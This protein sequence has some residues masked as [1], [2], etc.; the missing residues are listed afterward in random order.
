[1]PSAIPSTGRFQLSA[2]V[3]RCG[4]I[5]LTVVSFI[6]AAGAAHGQTVF[7]QNGFGTNHGTYSVL[8]YE[9]IDP[10]SGNLMLVVT[11]LAL[12]GNAGLDLRVQRVYN[13]AVYPDFESGSL[14]LEEDS[15]AG[16]GWRLHF[17]RVLHEDS[18]DS[19]GTQIEMGDGSRHS[20]YTTS[21]RPEGWTTKNFWIYD[22]SAH[23]LKLPNGTVYTF[24]HAVFLNARLGVVRYVT[25]IRDPFNNTITFSYFSSPGPPDGVQQIQQTLAPGQTRTVTFTYDGTYKGLRTMTFDGRTWTYEHQAFGPPG[26]SALV[27]TQAPTGKPWVYTYEST[28]GH[29]ALASMLVPGGGQVSYVYGDVT[30]YAGAT[31][32]PA[33]VV[34]SRSISGHQITAGTWTFTYSDGPNKDQS[35]VQSPCGTVRYRF[36]GIGLSGDFS[37]WSTGALAEQTVEEAGT[38]LER[39]ELTWVRSDAISPDAVPGEGGL[40][41]DAD[42]YNALLSK[43]V[44]RRGVHSW[45]TDF[46]YHTANFNDYHQAWRITGSGELTRITT[47]TFENGFGATSYIL[48]RVRTEN[49]QIGA[50]I[51]SSSWTYNLTTGFLNEQTVLGIRTRFEPSSVGNVERILDAHD[52][53]TQFLYQ[54]GVPR[55]IRT[56]LTKTVRTIDPVG[57][58]LS[59]TIDPDGSTPLTTTYEYDLGLRPTFVRP[60][61]ANFIRYEYDGVHQE[62]IR[63]ARGPG[64]LSN[65]LD[66][67]GRTVSSFNSLGLKTRVSRDAC[68]RGTF[69]SAPYTSGAGNRGVTTQF[70]ALGR[71]KQVT[72]ADN[73]SVTQ[74][75]Y[76]GIDVTI[77]DAENRQTRYD[78]SAFGAPGDGRLIG[79]RDAAL[80][81]T[82]Y[83]YDVLGNLKQV[84]GPGTTPSRTWVF[85]GRGLPLSDTMPE[86]GTTTYVYDVAG[87]LKKVTDAKG[88]VADLMYDVAGR[89]KQRD[90]TGTDADVIVTYDT[91]GRHATSSTSSVVTTY[92]YDNAGRLASR[93]DQ[94]L[95]LT[96]LSTY[97]YDNNDNLTRITYPSGRQ[98]T[99]EYDAE[100]RLLRVRNNGVVF[101]DT[102]TYDESGRL[103]SYVT[104]AVT[105]TMNYDDRDRVQRLRAGLSGSP[106]LDLTYG[107]NRV[108]HVKTITDARPGMSQSFD[109]DAL[110]RLKT[111]NGAY[112]TM[113]WTYDAAGNRLTESRGSTTV[114]N[115]DLAKQRLTSTTGGLSESFAY[116]AIGQLTSDGRGTYAYTAGGMLATATT[117]STTASYLYDADALRL[118]HQVNGRTLFTVRSSG[119]N[120]LS[121][122]DNLCGLGVWTRDVIYAGA[123]ALGS[124][125]AQSTSPS[126]GFVNAASTV[127]E[128][129][130]SVSPNV[131]LS[132]PGGGN[133]ACAVTVSYQTQPG[134]GVSGTDF[135]GTGGTVTFSAGSAHGS[136]KPLSVPIPIVNGSQDE[137][138]E[139]L[140]I[141]LTQGVGA[142]IA[143]PASHTVTIQ[144]DDPPP[145]V[146]VNDVTVSEA[147]GN[148]VFTVTVSQPSAFQITVN[149]ATAD[150]SAWA[151]KDYTARTG[152]LIIPPLAASATISVPVLEDARAELA[153]T[154]LITLSAPVN[155][156][157][158]DAQGVGTIT[159]NER[160]RAP[161]NLSLPGQ[162]FPDV[163]TANDFTY[164][165]VFNPHTVAATAR[166][167]YTRPDGSGVVHDHAVPARTRFTFALFGQPDVGGE[168]EMSVAVQ[169]PDPSK[170]LI[171]EQATYWGQPF[172]QSGR[173]TAGAT[174]LSSTWYFAEGSQGSF[175]TEDLAIYNLTDGPIDVVIDTFT[176][177]GA[178]LGQVIRRIEEGPGRVKLRLN[179]LLSGPG[180][181]GT[182]IIGRNLAGVEIPIAVERTMLWANGNRD[183]ANSSVGVSAASEHWYFAEGGKGFFSTFLSLFNPWPTGPSTVTVRYLHENGNTYTQNLSVAATSRIAVNPPAS[184]PDGGFGIHV[185][186]SASVPVIAERSMYGGSGW[187]LG[188]L[189]TGSPSV[190]NGWL[191]AEGSTTLFDTWFVLSNPRSTPSVVIFTFWKTDG[192]TLL[193]SVTVPANGRVAVNANAV[194]NLNN[195][196]FATRVTTDG[197]PI[198]IE[199]SMYSPKGATWA[200]AHVSLGRPF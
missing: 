31:T 97:G 91:L 168:G 145:T 32:K 117:P 103:S 34:T 7:D 108:S 172:W 150:Q 4:L 123:R 62:W 158:A 24:G 68:G 67:F 41:G 173:A 190:A 161:L 35:V 10:L 58:T 14:A 99:Y 100:D 23:T 56:A 189:E 39:E 74:Y 1:L 137:P 11:D 169:S 37:A 95:T 115:Y 51:V 154:F 38:V 2:L 188:H 153:E 132:V 33:R 165:S 109:Y 147:A 84:S 110:D 166:V 18:M 143:V 183:E 93:T 112:G 40:W 170:P 196:D 72:A 71:V 179:D 5:L 36:L 26:H 185:Q 142:T 180:D 197:N 81:N 193:H 96:F 63:I 85:D 131:V 86:S 167:T 28:P 149:Y 187:P 82:N 21:A 120:V 182:R 144:D 136:T 195:S 152:T 61:N 101:A 49:L 22:K 66:G 9:H 186:S 118:A 87:Q 127:P 64:Q 181:H 157:L 159:D 126:V 59:E 139:T 15:W 29:V 164:L 141:T 138:D 75:A 124:I 148:A 146:S 171:A 30:R 60:P 125:K 107:Y 102:F 90:S 70:D 80:Q 3:R 176:S 53:W 104:G 119:G 77:T 94:F 133:L 178:S 191:F 106:A 155:A 76:D 184:M 160:P 47:R 116:D 19:G 79:V 65:Q 192:T 6:A 98:V 92:G 17:G 57:L 20:L 12:P 156:T 200:G 140:L 151:G 177:T 113:T 114:Y 73:V 16:I 52:R 174:G 121:E 44:T 83:S 50:E 128:S 122:Y 48:P 162:F 46:E 111:A 199:R 27:S 43:R 129:V 88:Q 45:T 105:H 134:S 163:T 25:E 198:V 130:G 54:W 135:V 42:V 175:F 8:P 69:Q 13:S 55:Q 89:F 194:P 78:Y